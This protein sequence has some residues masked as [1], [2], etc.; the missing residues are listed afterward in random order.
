M[1]HAKGYQDYARLDSL[2][3]HRVRIDGFDTDGQPLCICTYPVIG[4]D[5]EQIDGWCFK[6]NNV[7]IL[8]CK[9]RGHDIREVSDFRAA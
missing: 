2:P 5:N 6:C 1:K 7:A 3:R 4:A 9:K 8:K